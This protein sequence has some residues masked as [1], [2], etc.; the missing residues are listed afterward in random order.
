MKKKTNY[1]IEIQ[2]PDFLQESNGKDEM[3]ILYIAQQ[4]HSCMAYGALT[5]LITL[6]NIDIAK[7]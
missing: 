4:I 6:Q 3:N 7:N 1:R 2:Y 5:L